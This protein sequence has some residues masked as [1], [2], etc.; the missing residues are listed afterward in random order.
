MS[1]DCRASS[2][3]NVLLNTC[4]FRVHNGSLFLGV[5]VIHLLFF[6]LLFCSEFSSLDATNIKEN[7]K[8]VRTCF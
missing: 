6:L 4:Y 3:L 7:N 2:Y 5:F 1:G 8:L